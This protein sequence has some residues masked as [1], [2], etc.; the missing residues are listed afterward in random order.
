MPIRANAT[1]AVVTRKR[2]LVGLDIRVG[3]D[4]VAASVQL[5]A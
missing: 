3:M 5:H 1:S 2:L 4:R